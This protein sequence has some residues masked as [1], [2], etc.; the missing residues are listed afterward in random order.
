MKKFAIGMAALACF[1]IGVGIGNTQDTTT[2]L[3]YFLTDLRAGF[4]GTNLSTGFKSKDGLSTAPGYGF[5]SETNTGIYRAGTNSLGFTVNST[6]TASMG[7]GTL[8]LSASGGSFQL[9][10][11]KSIILTAPT[12]SSGFGTSPSIASNNFSSTFRVNVGTGGVATSGVVGLPTA[13]NGW[14]CVVQDLS[15][16]VVTRQTASNTT[17][18]TVTAASAWTASDILIFICAGY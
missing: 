1:L 2:L 3:S 8:S 7:A 9:G 13:N 16:N 15:T 10:G 4:I 6:V 12:I 17:T 18:V 5:A 14:N 11:V